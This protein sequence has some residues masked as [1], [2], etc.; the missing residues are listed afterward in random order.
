MGI[1]T[2][3][4]KNSFLSPWLKFLTVTIVGLLGSGLKNSQTETNSGLTLSESSLEDSTQQFKSSYGFIFAKAD[5]Y[6]LYAPPSLASLE[7]VA[8]ATLPMPV[9]ESCSSDLVK[10]EL[11]RDIQNK[12]TQLKERNQPLIKQAIES[13]ESGRDASHNFYTSEGT[14]YYFYQAQAALS[15][16]N[17]EIRAINGEIKG[18]QAQTEAEITVLRQAAGC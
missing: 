7:D 5:T 1:H 13:Q 6:Q 10:Y 15:V 12:L 14:A 11:T 8:P 9:I 4:R 16:A 18:H 17:R 2:I 3:N